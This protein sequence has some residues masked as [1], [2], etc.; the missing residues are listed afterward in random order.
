MLSYARLKEIATQNGHAATEVER[1]AMARELL[2]VR[3]AIGPFVAVARAVDPV[4][5]KDDNTV[6]HAGPS[7]VVTV[8]DCRNLLAAYGD[9][10]EARDDQR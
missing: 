7:A 3:E 6:W 4:F 8:G 2:A 10:A 1:I 9:G 5:I